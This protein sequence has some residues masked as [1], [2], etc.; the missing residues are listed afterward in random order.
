MLRLTVQTFDSPFDCKRKVSYPNGGGHRSVRA[1]QA[2]VMWSRRPAKQR[3][4]Y[5]PQPLRVEKIDQG[6]LIHKLSDTT[7]QWHPYQQVT[8]ERTSF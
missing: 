4:D 7:G 2:S 3:R 6:V 8:L 5:I 1:L